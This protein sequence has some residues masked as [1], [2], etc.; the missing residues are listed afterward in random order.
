MRQLETL[1]LT[2]Q[3]VTLGTNLPIESLM[4]LLKGHSKSRNR[5]LGWLL[6]P[7]IGVIAALM[8]I[9]LG[10]AQVEPKQVN[11]VSVIDPCSDAELEQWLL[12]KSDSREPKLGKSTIIGGVVVGTVECDNSRYSYALGFKEPKRVLTFKKLDS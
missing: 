12:G 1:T 9:P 3:R 10:K 4:A 5:P 6:L 11:Q 2:D 8:L 7:A